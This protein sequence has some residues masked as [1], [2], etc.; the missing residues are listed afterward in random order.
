MRGGN[1]HGMAQYGRQN[2]ERFRELTD[3]AGRQYAED[4]F[5]YG[6]Q[7]GDV[8]AQTTVTNSLTIEHNSSFEWVQAGTDNPYVPI[9]VNL[10]DQRSTRTFMNIP[11]LLGCLFGWG[12]NSGTPYTLP[13]F[14]RFMSL[15][16]LNITLNNFSAATDITECDLSFIGRKLFQEKGPGTQGMGG[17]LPELFNTWRDDATGKVYSDDFFMYVFSSGALAMGD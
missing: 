6:Y 1:V 8:A 4:F 17:P 15:T 10:A 16:Q 2:F 14:R 12:G 11:P 3:Q 5:I 9:T 7:A 13:I